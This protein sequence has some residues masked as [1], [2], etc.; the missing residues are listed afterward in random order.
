MGVSLQEF[1]FHQVRQ[2]V[3]NWFDLDDS[4]S[5]AR[6]ADLRESFVSDSEFVQD[7]RVNPLML[8]LM[9]GIYSSEKIVYHGT[10]LMYMKSARFYCLRNG[11]S[12]V[13]L[14]HPCRLMRTYRPQCGH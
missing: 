5:L 4:V 7:L 13:V 1:T 10:G 11:I 12:I 6:K 8:S 3:S 9:C 14:I 2:Y